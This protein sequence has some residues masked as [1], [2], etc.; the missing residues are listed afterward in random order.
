LDAAYSTLITDYDTDEEI[1]AN[2]S[3]YA[4][5]I[6]NLETAITNAQTSI[7]NF[8]ILNDLISNANT[9]ATTV[10][11]YSAPTDAESVYSSN[12]DKDPVALTTAVRNEIAR[13]SVAHGGGT[14]ITAMIANSGFEL[15]S[16][17]GWSVTTKE[18]DT[19]VQ[20][21][22][23]SGAIYGTD[24][25]GGTYF[26]N[27]FPNGNTLSQNIGTLK[28]GK[29]T[30]SANAASSGA[31]LYLVVNGTPNTG[32]VTNA[33]ANLTYTF[34]L[35]SDAE[36]TI[37]IS[38]GDNYTGEYLDEGGN[39]WYKCDDFSLTYVGQDELAQA[40]A[41][42][43]DEITAATTV[44]NN[45]SA[46]VGTAPFLYP[47][48]TYNT[49]VTEL[50]EAQAVIDANGTEVD[51]YN[52]AKD[53]LETAK[54]AMSS[55]SQN[56]P[57][58]DKYYRIFVANN[59]GTASDYNLNMLY[60]TTMTQ[61]KVTSMAYPVKFVAST[62]SY[63]GRYR[64]QT[65][66]SNNLCTTKNA[67]TIAYV[68]SAD[69]V[70]ERLVD[71]S[72]SL[73]DNGTVKMSST[74]SGNSYYYAASA[75]ENANVTATTGNTGTWVVSDA[76]E[77]SNTSL[78]VN[79]TAGWG[80]F[81]APYDNLTPSTV[82]AYTVSYTENNVVYFTENETGVLSANTPYVL[83]TEEA[84]D[85]SKT[86]TG[87]ANNDNDTYAVNGLVGLLTASEV[88]AD[89]YVLQY[90][91]G[92]VGFYKTTSSITGT[93]NRC[94]L[95]LSSVPT[96]ASSSRAT[97]FFDLFDS[98]TSGI[99]QIGDGQ[100]KM[101]DGIYNLNGQRVSKPAKG[102]YIINGKKVIIK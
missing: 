59:D 85:V 28:A 75:S 10:T 101:E 82:K 90:N 5:A 98:E 84:D 63:A 78:S 24:G 13:A 11:E 58:P 67:L 35:A 37:A 46:K 60:E 93:A 74:N 55:A 80:T 99:A 21:V 54:N 83:S 91:D 56:T 40:K 17:T 71:I 94:Y 49:L 66:Y 96:E 50:T 12:A 32:N 95:D 61:V 45:Y 26:F 81:I 3:G 88:P 18:S 27:C 51:A 33:V 53:E 36:V 25:F 23:N 89:S 52:D 77:V 16:M 8:I 72:I 7:N 31:T 20:V 42:L 47:I 92:K 43:T 34:T 30:L 29:Y 69:G 62:G 22:E 102:L 87:I 6:S 19:D 39:W 4:T 2:I 41:G 44:K 48:A 76:V 79:A 73:Q 14:D 15:G 100:L 38:G 70:E 9:F 64:I 97:I 86:F 57:D 68:S 1:V 65:P